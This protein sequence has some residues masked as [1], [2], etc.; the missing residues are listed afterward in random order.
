MI[1]MM[2]ERTRA[3]VGLPSS[4][5]NSRQCIASPQ[6]EVLRKSYKPEVAIRQPEFAQISISVL[7]TSRLTTSM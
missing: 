6:N 2:G 5:M 1:V 3:T 7:K 4:I